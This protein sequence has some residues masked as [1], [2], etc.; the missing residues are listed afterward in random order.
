MFANNWALSYAL[1]DAYFRLARDSEID[2]R[3]IAQPAE[4]PYTDRYVRWC[5][6]ESGRPPTYV[7][8]RRATIAFPFRRGWR[9]GFLPLDA[10]NAGKPGVKPGLSNRSGKEDQLMILLLVKFAHALCG[11]LTVMFLWRRKAPR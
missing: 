2:W 10:S 9:S 6:R 5:D 4:P 1:P 3:P 11:R 7:Y 8:L